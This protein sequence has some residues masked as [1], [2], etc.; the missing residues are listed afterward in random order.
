MNQHVSVATLDRPTEKEL[1]LSAHLRRLAFHQSIA[2]KAAELKA[3]KLREASE[4]F[5]TPMRTALSVHAIAPEA[6][7][8]EP[9]P[10]KEKHWFWIAGLVPGTLSIA[11]VKHAV[12]DEFGLKI[13]HLDSP[14]RTAKFVIA[15][16]I[17]MWLC[18]DLLPHR[19]LPE[20]GRRMGNRDHTTVL[21]ACRVAPRKVA[22][23][24]KLTER[25]ARIRAELSPAP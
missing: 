17:A 16:Q 12:A 4:Q 21:H 10:P 11:A 13:E 19:S 7:P 3:S 15:R 24:E 23:C 5:G 1:A 14:R 20:I 18:K 22:A 2:D 6:M 8:A 9:D 25:V